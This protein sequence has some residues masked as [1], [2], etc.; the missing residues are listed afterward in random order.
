MLSFFRR[1]RK[2]LYGSGQAR[3]YFIYAIGEIALVVVGILIALQ[4]NNWNEQRKLKQLGRELLYKTQSDLIE[5][6]QELENDIES[7]LQTIEWYKMIIDYIEEKRPYTDSLHEAISYITSWESPFLTFTTY[8]TLKAKGIELIQNDSIEI[9]LVQLYE[10]GF[11]HL[12]NDYDRAEW[13]L[14]T[15]VTLPFAS[16]NLSYDLLNRQRAAANDSEKLKNSDE[17]NNILRML[18]RMRKRGITY[19][20]ELVEKIEEILQ[21]IRESQKRN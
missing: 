20:T 15:S 14:S 11:A 2:G 19:S 3:K 1:I 16:R 5:S 4:I 8:E 18:I 9:K 21:L 13:N 6:K 12:I 10:R 7:N 17:F